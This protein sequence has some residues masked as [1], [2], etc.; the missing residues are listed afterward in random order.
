MSAPKTHLQRLWGFHKRFYRHKRQLIPG[1]LAVPLVAICDI[2][3]TVVFGDSLTRLREG[4][5]AEFLAGVFVLLLAISALGGLFRFFQR[6]LLVGVSRRFEVDLKRELFQKLCR[7]PLR[8]HARSRS[9]DIVSRSTADIENLRML[10][11]P[12]LLMYVLS[13]F[14]MVP[15]ALFIMFGI[16]VKVTLSMMLPLVITGVAMKLLSPRIHRASIE[17]QE[18]LGDLSHRA[19]ESF[20]GIRVI[21]GY[22]LQRHEQEDFEKF[23]KSNR[24]HQLEMASARGLMHSFVN[25][26]FDMT[27]LPILFVGGLGMIDRNLNVGDLFKFIDLTA[28][29]FWP[30]IALGWMAGL[31]PR[32]VV[33]ATRIEE[34]LDEDLHIDDPEHPI[35]LDP[36]RGEL[37]LKRVG[38][39]Y[40]GETEPALQDIDV[41]IPAGTTLG[42]VGPTGSGKSTL[43]NL[44]GRLL[45]AEGRIELDGIG[46]RDLSLDTLRGATAY[47]PQ[48]SFLFS[49]SYRRN[50]EFGAAH[51]LGD[52][53][54]AELIELAGMTEEVAQ[55]EHG[56]E[57]M[58]GER[59]VTLSGGQRQRTCIARALARKPRILI[60]DDALS[61]VDTETEVK[62]K[63]SLRRAGQG[64]TVILSAHRLATVRDAENIVVLQRGRIEAQGTHEQVLKLS[65]WYRDTWDRQR[66][67]DELERL[68]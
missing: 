6:W 49:D 61:A 62:L 25:L 47:V 37:S 5:D 34:V 56:L 14:V 23:S 3:L 30:V 50:L 55:F 60:L 43:L 29:V 35:P 9:G 38:F 21:K 44:I 12:G 54:L 24:D 22:G 39:T 11:G 40:D 51:E 1:L 57:Q 20:A 48:D 27:S 16:S 33:S 63:R 42:V 52:E 8:F 2:W 31:F 65:S 41:E 58:I 67:Q 18:S 4:S 36:V 13:A 32:A 66:M 26:S 28:K 53:T 45:E 59:G 10:L 15:G 17:V 46:I 64:R 19:Q 68:Q 7:L